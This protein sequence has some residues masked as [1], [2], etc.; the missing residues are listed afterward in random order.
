[1][2]CETVK[3]VRPVQDR[4]RWHSLLNMEM[5]PHVETSLLLR[6]YTASLRKWPHTL[7]NDVVV[8][9]ATVQT[10]R[11]NSVTSPPSKA[12]TSTTPLRKVRPTE[13]IRNRA[14]TPREMFHC[15]ILEVLL[16]I[17]QWDAHGN[18]WPCSVSRTTR[19]IALHHLFFVGQPASIQTC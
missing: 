7:R 14:A 5:S 6:C 8:Y 19:S 10:P 15:R 13:K 16:I 11:K 12:E 18:D 3:W 2:V 4:A 17:H 1:M 9:S